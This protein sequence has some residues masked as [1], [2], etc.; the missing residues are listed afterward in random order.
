VAL[1]AHLDIVCAGDG[2]PKGGRSMRRLTSA[3]SVCALALGAVACS[4]EGSME[5]AGKAM[6]EAMED[7]R[8]AGADALDQAGEKLDEAGEK[9]DEAGEKAKKMAEGQH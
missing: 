5:K 6:D 7:A 8:D 9:L 4:E 2:R 3:L 1:D